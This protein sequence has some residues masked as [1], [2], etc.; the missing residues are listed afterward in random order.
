VLS[1]KKYWEKPENDA[2]GNAQG[3]LTHLVV[4][5]TISLYYQGKS[6]TFGLTP[7]KENRKYPS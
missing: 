2:S 4:N 7:T 6:L 1:G 3:R 5:K